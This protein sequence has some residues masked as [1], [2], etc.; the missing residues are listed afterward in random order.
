QAEN[1]RQVDDR[2][3]AALLQHGAH[4]GATAVKDAGEV[5][6]DDRPPALVG[7]GINWTVAK[8]P[9]TDTRAVERHLRPAES[10]AAPRDRRLDLG[11]IGYVGGKGLNRRRCFDSAHVEIDGKHLRALRD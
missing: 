9:T 11:R 6:V 5:G 1:A 4:L 2:P 3:T 7:T 8:P 10:L